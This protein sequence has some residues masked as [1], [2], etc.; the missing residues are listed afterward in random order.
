M[1]KLFLTIVLFCLSLGPVL[2]GGQNVGKTLP[3]LGVDFVAN[4][5]AAT[6]GKPLLVEFWATWCPPCRQSIPHL[7]QLHKTYKG[8]GLIVV[9]ITNETKSKVDEFRKTLPMDYA[10]GL[11]AG[12]KYS[13]QFGISGIPHALLVNSAGKI[14]WEGHPMELQGAE[15]E[16]ILPTAA[17]TGTTP[18]S[19]SPLPAP[20]PG[21]KRF[22]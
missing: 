3:P 12:G 6:A 11:D 18:G 20:A 1:K 21:N 2:A 10:V 22:Y 7:N 19:P 5:P 13:G 16:K 9:G 4:P 15:I 14:V 17:A 8:R